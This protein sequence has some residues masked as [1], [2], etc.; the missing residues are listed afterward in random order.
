MKRKLLFL[1]MIVG[2][3]AVGSAA[4]AEKW[5]LGKSDRVLG[6]TDGEFFVACEGTRV[7]LTK[8]PQLK[9]QDAPNMYCRRDGVIDSW[10]GDGGSPSPAL[11]RERQRIRKILDEYERDYPQRKPQ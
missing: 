7:D 5:L 6:K 3:L 8:Y 11:T 4:Q 10:P 2:L 9:V 1:T